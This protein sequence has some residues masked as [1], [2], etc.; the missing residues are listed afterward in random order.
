MSYANPLHPPVSAAR[1][2]GYSSLGVV[3]PRDAM[4]P[5]FL[6]PSRRR[7]PQATY[8][9]SCK[10]RMATGRRNQLRCPITFDYLGYSKQGIS[11]VETLAKGV[12]GL[13][14]MIQGPNDQVFANTGLTRITFRILVCF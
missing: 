3:T 6:S 12:P 14:R 13:L 4:L 5:Q 10:W 1:L 7:L 9:P 11:V 8:A 2:S